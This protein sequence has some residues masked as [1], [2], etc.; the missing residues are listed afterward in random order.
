MFILPLFLL[1]G[2]VSASSPDICTQLCELDGPDI[3]TR[4]SWTKDGICHGYVFRGMPALNNYCYHTSET[5]ATCP[6]YGLPVSVED[7]QRL[8]ALKR[9]VP[10]QDP[11]IAPGDV[12]VEIGNRD[13]AGLD[14]E[15]KRLRLVRSV[16]PHRAYRLANVV[17]V[18]R[19]Q[20]FIDSVHRLSHN[21]F[22][23]PIHAYFKHE[24]GYGPGLTKEWVA[25]VTRQI[26]NPDNGYF[27]INPESPNFYRI[28]PGGFNIPDPV[29]CWN[30]FKKSIGL[31]P[32][33][34]KEIY[35]AIGKF[36]AGSLVL[37]QP[38]G[39]HLPIMFYGALIG[40]TL[41]LD[42]IREEEPILARSLDYLMSLE[43][44]EELAAF[45]LEINGEDVVPTLQNRESVIRDKVN[46]L[47]RAGERPGLNAIREGF[48]SI[49]PEANVRQHVRAADL[50]A[51]IRGQSFID[52]DDLFAESTIFI[53]AGQSAWLR[54]VLTSFTQD[55]RRQF[56]KFVT[57]MEQL[58]VGG[59]KHVNP[60]ITIRPNLAPGMHLLPR[61][62]LCQN[63]LMLPTYR[64]AQEMRERLLTAIQYGTGWAGD[65]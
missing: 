42:D 54:E 21:L 8:V 18:R 1:A 48:F 53:S 29:G 47:I 57:N 23:R 7:A 35:T 19:E 38:L 10:P 27:S 62:Y 22:A 12:M 63:L 51:L 17:S 11:A 39:V 43:T 40:E 65:N 56:L 14:I 32:L 34:S 44:D 3:C 24:P 13:V 5:A 26:F 60:K 6:F 2:I 45:P 33:T 16:Y 4:G 49:F 20:A 58:P 59:F 37:A 28:N 52:I 36:L 41:T 55:E 9:N 64:S 30:R 61:V 25:E 50:R 31:G 15:A 46:S